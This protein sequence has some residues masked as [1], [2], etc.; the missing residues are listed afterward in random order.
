MYA[1]AILAIP[2]TR[3]T[4]ELIF[5]HLVHSSNKQW[6][7]PQVLPILYSNSIS[8]ITGVGNNSNKRIAFVEDTFTYAAYRNGSFYNLYKKYIPITDKPST[9]STITTDL[10]LLKNRPIPHGPSHIMLIPD[11]SQTSLT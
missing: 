7:K 2:G 9:V 6:E 3:V 4:F 10:N 1:G 11:S 8:H 5:S